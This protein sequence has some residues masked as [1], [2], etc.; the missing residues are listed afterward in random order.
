MKVIIALFSLLAAVAIAAPAT[1]DGMPVLGR[2]FPCAILTIVTARSDTE[3]AMSDGQ[4]GA[5]PYQNTG[6][7]AG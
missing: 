3:P 2:L 6:T 7:P 1:I 4:G 5:I